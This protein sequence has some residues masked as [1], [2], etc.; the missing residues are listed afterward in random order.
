MPSLRFW[1]RRRALIQMG[2]VALA[3][4]MG[5]LQLPGYEPILSLPVL[6][7]TLLGWWMSAEDQDRAEKQEK[8]TDERNADI[9]S[10]RD[11]I[12]VERREAEA[13]PDRI[14][15]LARAAAPELRADI[16]KLAARMIA[17]D[18][19]RSVAFTSSLS[20]GP[21]SAEV[22]SALWQAQNDAMDAKYARV[23]ADYR[24]DLL[25]EMQATEIELLRRLD[26]RQ[27]ERGTHR[28]GAFDGSLAGAQPLTAAAGYLRELARELG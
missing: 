20:S 4:V 26:N 19:A 14:R 24:R 6:M 2:S 11:Q 25:P 13:F 5:L 7:F 23:V 27:P 15:L 21:V 3:G 8:I 22:R 17:T 1:F 18:E 28:T 16:E 10:L 9:E 12:L